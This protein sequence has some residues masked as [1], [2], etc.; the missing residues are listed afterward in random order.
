[1]NQIDEILLLRRRGLSLQEIADKV[2][3]TRLDIRRIL[4]RAGAR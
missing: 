3:L 1:M 2:G 4:Q